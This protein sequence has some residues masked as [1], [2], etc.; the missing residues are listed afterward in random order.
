MNLVR[1]CLKI[2]HMIQ[3]LK[4]KRDLP[5]LSKLVQL[6]T[7]SGLVDSE[8][9]MESRNGQ[10]VLFMKGTGKTIVHTAKE[11][12]FTSTATFTMAIG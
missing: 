10:M 2:D 5:I 12:S 1:L 8:M 4:E 11:N 9:D 7:A 6:T 3:T